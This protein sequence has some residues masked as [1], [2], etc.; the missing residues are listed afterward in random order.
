MA[1]PGRF[2]L[3]ALPVAVMP[4]SALAQASADTY[5]YDA[6]GRVVAV[7]AGTGAKTDYTF[8]SVG[9]R[10]A[11]ATQR[12]LDTNASMETW[13]AEALPHAT[14]FAQYAGW[15]ASVGYPTS[16]LTYGPYTNSVPTGAHNAVWRMMIDNNTNPSPDTVVTLDVNDSEADQVLASRTLTWTS[17][18]APMA[19]QIFELPFTTTAAQLGHHLEFRTWFAGKAY[20]NVDKISRY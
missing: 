10:T 16:A 8:D 12:Q 2:I 14:G 11:V 17:F 19:Y 4:A 13:E 18:A 20:I 1:F 9:N 15:A 6:L 7:Q 5:R 3:L